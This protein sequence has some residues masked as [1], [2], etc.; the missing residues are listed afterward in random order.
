MKPI[1]TNGNVEAKVIVEPGSQ[2]RL[3]ELQFKFGGRPILSKTELAPL[4]TGG[5]GK[6]LN[7]QEMRQTLENLPR[8]YV[9]H[10]YPNV[11]M[12]PETRSNDQKRNLH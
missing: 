6:I 8:Y 5:S 2:Y 10:G 1:I 12:V 7:I 4:I 3:R 11:T 9:S